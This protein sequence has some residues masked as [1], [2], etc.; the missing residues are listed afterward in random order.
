MRLKEGVN[1]WGDPQGQGWLFDAL[2]DLNAELNLIRDLDW[3]EVIEEDLW[4]LVYNLDS[5]CWDSDSQNAFVEFAMDASLLLG[6]RTL[7]SEFFSWAKPR[8]NVLSRHEAAMEFLNSLNGIEELRQ[9]L[10]SSSGH[11]KDSLVAADVDIKWNSL[12]LVSMVDVAHKN[13]ASSTALHDVLADELL[14]LYKECGLVWFLGGL[15]DLN[16]NDSNF[17]DQRNEILTPV[18]SALI[19]T[20][21]YAVVLIDDTNIPVWEEHLDVIDHRGFTKSLNEIVAAAKSVHFGR[22]DRNLIWDSLQRGT[23]I[24]SEPHQ[25]DA[26]LASFGVKH[27]AKLNHVLSE[28][29]HEIPPV[30]VVD[31][32]CG[33]GLGTLAVLESDWDVSRVKEVV[34]VEPS[35]IALRRAEFL[36]N[37]HESWRGM[38]VVPNVIGLNGF[39]ISETFLERQFEGATLHV[40]SNVL[41]MEAVDLDGLVALIRSTFSGLQMVVSVSP[42]MSRMRTMRLRAFQERFSNCQDYMVYQEIDEGRLSMGNATITA[43]L[44]SF[45][46]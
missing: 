34:L 20:I 6:N 15:T 19:G 43:R 25:L 7:F 4:S 41:D 39:L 1:L 14:S 32:S 21:E 24:I 36:I 46:L 18:Y 38:Q 45:R 31:W 30:R 10:P 23:A 44:F 17:L 33:Q 16:P 35:M 22:S 42:F 11:M 2:E 26:Y 8:F 28:P 29:F 9:G 40:F 5:G 37:H 13:L 27:I 3:V 12:T